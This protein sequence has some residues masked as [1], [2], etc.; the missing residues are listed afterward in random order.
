[1]PLTTHGCINRKIVFAYD[2]SSSLKDQPSA[3]PWRLQVLPSASPAFQAVLE[4]FAVGLPAERPT[5]IEIHR[6]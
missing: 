6:E 4:F 1:M 2:H 3:L 5:T